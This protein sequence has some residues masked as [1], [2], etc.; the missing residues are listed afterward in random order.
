MFVM[1]QIE[2][3]RL[4]A[5]PREKSLSDLTKDELY[6]RVVAVSQT[7]ENPR[8]VSRR[9][10]DSLLPRLGIRA[11]FHGY[12]TP[13]DAACI[14]GWI[15]NRENFKSASDYARELG[16]EIYKSFQKWSN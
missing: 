12:Y 1:D 13:A 14:V 11:D 15:Y 9:T 5:F 7:H 8:N 3:T 4:V 10:F 2:L 16:S 6:L